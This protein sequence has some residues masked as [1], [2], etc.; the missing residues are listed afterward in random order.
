MQPII[1]PFPF[2]FT[3]AQALFHLS[4]VDVCG[5]SLQMLMFV[6]RVCVVRNT[7]LKVYY[8]RYFL[9]KVYLETYLNLKTCPTTFSPFR[10]I[11]TLNCYSRFISFL[12]CKIIFPKFQR[13]FRQDFLEN[14][15][16]DWVTITPPPQLIIVSAHR[17]LPPNYYFHFQS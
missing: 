14:E 4:D 9:L 16:L 2:A 11:S 15:N 1:P 10:F 8:Y 7:L 5:E 17:H 6:V 13:I 12:N 3:F